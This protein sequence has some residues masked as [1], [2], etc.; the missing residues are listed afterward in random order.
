MSKLGPEAVTGGVLYPTLLKKRPWH[1]C[2]PVSFA[3]FLRTSFLQNTYVQLLLFLQES[4]SSGKWLIT[5]CKPC[6][7]I[8]CFYYIIAEIYYMASKYHSHNDK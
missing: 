7:I 5:C 8:F 4:S 6:V 2:F 3:K 1:K